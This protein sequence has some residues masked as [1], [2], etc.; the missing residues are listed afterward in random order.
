MKS[1]QIIFL[2]L[3][4]LF[5]T[6][7]TF[8]QFGNEEL[9]NPVDWTFESAKKV[10]DRYELKFTASIDEGWHIYSHFISDGGPI[11]TNFIFEENEAVEI[12]DKL[13]E[14]GNIVAK[15][16]EAF[17]MELSWYENEV[18]FIQK[19]KLKNGY[20]GAI[21]KGELEFMVCDDEKCLPPDYIPFTFAIGNAEAVEEDNEEQEESVFWS[22]RIL[23]EGEHLKVEWKVTL[24]KDWQIYSQHIEEGGPIP[25]TFIFDDRENIERLGEVSE[26]GELIKKK[27]ILFDNMELLS[28][29]DEVIFSQLLKWLDTRDPILS[30]A[31]EYM[32]CDIEACIFDGLDFKIDLTKIGEWNVLPKDIITVG[33]LPPDVEGLPDIMQDGALTKDGIANNCTGHEDKK[34]SY[35]LI[36]VLGLGGGLIALLTPCVFPMIPLTVSYFTKGSDKASA[37]GISN[38]LIYGLSI[39]VIYVALTMSVITAL[40]APMLNW[41]STDHIFNI[42]FFL[43][44][45]FFAFS[46]FGFYELELPSSWASKTDKLSAKG[47]LIGIFFM[48]FTLALV[49]FSCT[50]PIIGSL[51]LGV[52]N[53][54]FMGPFFGMLGFSLALAFP[55]TLFAIFPKWLNSLPKSGGWLNSVKVFLGFLELAFALK[56]FSVADL[57]QHWGILK[58]ELFIGIWVLV[59]ILLALYMFGVIRFPHDSKGSKPGKGKLLVGSASLVFAIYLF[60]GLI[61][62]KPLLGGIAPAPGY[63]FLRPSE[64]PQKIDVCFHDYEEGMAYAK[65]NRL[66]VLLDFTGHGCVNCR[67]MENNV[68]RKDEVNLVINKYVVISLYVDDRTDL[69]TEMHYVSNAGGRNRNIDKVGKYWV[70][71]QVRHFNQLSQPYYALLGPNGEILNQPVGYTPDKDKYIEFLECGLNN[72]TTVCPDCNR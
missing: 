24:G 26:E 72:L 15:H 65:K 42:V 56:F 34:K 41:I 69:P 47:G 9:L 53:E 66:P 63:S 10:G 1:L 67:L 55:F 5:C 28:Y 4:C 13:K 60:I 14:D 68:W 21:V 71:F 44:F 70:D 29:K 23:E 43:I 16:D 57:T 48:A 35:W 30:G 50:G 18:T 11:P 8:A 32:T 36:F 20:D 2:G 45:V 64:C 54:G 12:K 3:L 37:K 6:S 17:D 61:N 7:E 62:F 59:F 39:I 25:T 33:G 46:F 27:E 38:A 58:Y 31:I 52:V 22:Y 19:V 40:G 49:S 51:I